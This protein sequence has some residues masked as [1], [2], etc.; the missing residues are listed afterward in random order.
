L[1]DFAYVY[2]YAN[3]DFG[4]YRYDSKEETIQRYPDIHLVD[5]PVNTTPQK[6]NFMTR[7]ASLSTNG[8]VLLIAML[9][10]ALCVVI[11]IIFIFVMAFRKLSGPKNFIADD[12]DFSFDDV[13]IVGENDI[14]FNK[15]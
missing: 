4:L 11:L 10:A 14:D 3:G 1:S 12:V 5:A 9:I 15:K 13:T 8:K 6:D 2:C 7:F